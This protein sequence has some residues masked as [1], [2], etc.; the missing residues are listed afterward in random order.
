[1][2]RLSVR[3]ITSGRM[4][5]LNSVRGSGCLWP[6]M[7]FAQANTALDTTPGVDQR[8]AELLVAGWGT[9]M[10]CFGIED[11]FIATSE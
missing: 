5:R 6:P 8:G 3:E 10:P 9:D 2:P 7:S 1:M 11:S 4:A